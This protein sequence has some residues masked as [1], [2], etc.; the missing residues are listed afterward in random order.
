MKPNVDRFMWTVNAHGPNGQMTERIR[1]CFCNRAQN[2]VRKVPYEL[3]L[4]EAGK[5]LVQRDHFDWHWNVLQP[6]FTLLR[7][8]YDLI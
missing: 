8:D 5:A 1:K 2:C 3:I 7:C 4:V 6:L